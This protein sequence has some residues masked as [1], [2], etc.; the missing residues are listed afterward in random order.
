MLVNSLSKSADNGE[1]PSSENTTLP[2]VTSRGQ[3]I[4]PNVKEHEDCELKKEDL[5]RMI[6]LMDGFKASKVILNKSCIPLFLKISATFFYNKIYFL[7]FVI[8]AVD[9]KR[10]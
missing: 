8:M 9:V 10:I 6:E 2:L 3:V 7:I 4:E 5:Q 1:F